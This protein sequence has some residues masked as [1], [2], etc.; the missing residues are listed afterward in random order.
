MFTSKLRDQA[1]AKTKI[2]VTN[3]FERASASL[4]RS[5]TIPCRRMYK[6]Q[7]L[8][9]FAFFWKFQRAFVRSMCFL[10]KIRAETRAIDTYMN[11]NHRHGFVLSNSGAFRTLCSRKIPNSGLFTSFRSSELKVRKVRKFRSYFGILM[12]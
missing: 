12:V 11:E 3:R 10:S 6:L 1:R 9:S 8:S 7:V 4:Q 2:L 5:G